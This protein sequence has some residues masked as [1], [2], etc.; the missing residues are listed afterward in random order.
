MVNL[1]QCL[2][3]KRYYIG[4]LTKAPEWS[5]NGAL[6]NYQPQGA[7]A[8]AFVLSV[9][10]A[11]VE[12][13]GCCWAFPLRRRG[14]GSTMAGGWPR[15]AQAEGRLASAAGSHTSVSLSVNSK[16][17]SRNNKD[18]SPLSSMWVIG[19][20]ILRLVFYPVSTPLSPKKGPSY[21][22]PE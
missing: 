13:G 5:R 7:F 10:S 20:Y 3:L 18:V 12:L 11:A 16:P 8:V 22:V 2:E 19:L 6:I 1:Y 14:D 4:L 21:P 17:V 15:T 9:I